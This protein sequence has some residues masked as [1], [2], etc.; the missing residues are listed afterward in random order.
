MP[1]LKTALL[2]LRVGTAPHNPVSHWNETTFIL[3]PWLEMDRE[4]TARL[5]TRA[6]NWRRGVDLLRSDYAAPREITRPPSSPWQQLR[7]R[8]PVCHENQHGFRLRR[9]RQR[10]AAIMPSTPAVDG[11]G[12]VT[13]TFG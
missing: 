6:L 4:R 12:I 5:R 11:S 10:P 9:V 13:G 3:P 8:A 2:G 1:G 7:E